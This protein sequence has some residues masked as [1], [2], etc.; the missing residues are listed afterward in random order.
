MTSRLSQVKRIVLEL[1]ADGEEHTS[2]DIRRCIRDAGIELDQRSSVMR[3][4][5]YQLK[6]SGTEI[7]SRDRGVYQLRE[8][9]AEEKKD[10]L[11]DGFTVIMPCQKNVSRYV[12]IH[13]DGSVRINSALNREMKSQQIEIRISDTGKQLALIPDGDNSHKFTKTGQTKNM[14][15]VKRLKGNH[16]NIPAAYEMELDRDSGIWIGELC[17]KER[18]SVSANGKIRVR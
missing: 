11:L 12:Y 6:K 15:I 9:S 5:V 8:K 1:L 7:Y 16:I 10:S 17:K 13:S 14:E 4:A 3:T 2:D 18:M